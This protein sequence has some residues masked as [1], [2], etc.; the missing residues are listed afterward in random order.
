M[1]DFY[2]QRP[3]QPDGGDRPSYPKE[4]MSLGPRQGPML[5]ASKTQAPGWPKKPSPLVIHRLGL[6]PTGLDQ[7][8]PHG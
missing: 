7:H 2:F 4:G 3:D 1:S 8:R 5:L 6:Q